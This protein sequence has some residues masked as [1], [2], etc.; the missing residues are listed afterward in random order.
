MTPAKQ[1]IRVNLSPET[2]AK[3]RATINECGTNASEFGRVALEFY[4]DSL[5]KEA[6]EEKEKWDS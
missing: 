4:L 2:Y 3:V 6:R 5:E 1:N